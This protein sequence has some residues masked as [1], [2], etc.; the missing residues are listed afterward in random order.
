MND[1]SPNEVCKI[2]FV[3]QG[4]T[5]REKH[6]LIDSSITLYQFSIRLQV[7]IAAIFDFSI[8]TH[9]VTEAYLQSNEP[10]SRELFVKSSKDFRLEDDKL[11]RLNKPLYGLFDAGDYWDATKV[12][13][14]E[15][16]LGMRK[17]IGS[18]SLFLKREK[19]RLVGLA[20]TYVDKLL[21]CGAQDFV[22]LTKITGENVNSQEREFRNVTFSGIR[23]NT[24]SEGF[25]VSQPEY[26][27]KL[28]KL[29]KEPTITEVSSLRAKLS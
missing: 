16:D 21:Q 10:F 25:E 20:G 15:E 27:G 11:L 2:R 26:Y 8:W 19:G 18:A 13:H 3:A 29:G 6:F 1:L 9:D 23:T 24:T 4:H 12:Q 7:S 5:D 28:Q 17:T 14:Y 22:E